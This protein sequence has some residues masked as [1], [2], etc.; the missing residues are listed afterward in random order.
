[1]LTKSKQK[2]IKLKNKKIKKGSGDTFPHIFSV[3]SCGFRKKTSFTDDGRTEDDDD[4]RQ[5]RTPRQW[6]W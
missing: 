1:M 2:I 4:G 5:T 6:L 3:D